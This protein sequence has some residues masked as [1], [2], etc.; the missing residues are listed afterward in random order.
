[1]TTADK[2]PV[3]VILNPNAGKKVRGPMTAPTD[4]QIRAA[5]EGAGLRCEIHLT[6]SPEHADEL[7]ARLVA[8][9]HELI[10]A[11]G[12]DGTVGQVA[13][14]LLDTNVALGI[15][16]LGSVMNIAR[17]LGVPRDLEGAAQV[18]AAGRVESIDT[19]EADDGLSFFEAATVGINAAVFRDIQRLE[20]GEWGSPLRALRSAFLFAPARLTIAMDEGRVVTTRAMMVT[21]SNGAYTGAAI[22]IAPDARVDDGLFDVVIFRHY[23]KIELFVHLVSIMLGRR[24]YVPHTST[25]RSSVVRVESRRPL[26]TRA[27][28]ND[29]GHTPLEARVRPA[30]LRV[31]VGP[32]FENGRA[33]PDASAEA[34]AGA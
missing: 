31:V 8:E 20:D 26:P 17:M 24:R 15:V 34:P 10:L 14:E 25:Y 32:S 13:R 5:L 2:R 1:L 19:G 30:S 7:I 22:P 21:V 29:L 23:S 33:N 3:P 16:P 28:S 4:E 6:Q 11:A 27:D 18:I 12:G 9:G